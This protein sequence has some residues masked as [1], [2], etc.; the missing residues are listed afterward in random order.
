MKGL[1][2][3]FLERSLFVNLLSIIIVLVGG[4]L[5]YDMNREAFPNIEYDIVIV[6]T[7]WPGSSARDIEKLVTKPIEEKLKEVDGIKEYRSSS[8][9]GRSS[10]TI[11]IDPNVEDDKEIFDDIRN[12]VDRTEGLPS[13][14]EKPTVTEVS[15][16]NLP[17][18]Q[19]A[20]TRS[21]KEDGSFAVSYKQ[22]R[23]M[24]EILENRFLRIHGV[25]RIL[26]RGWRDTEIFVDM[27]P[28]RMRQYLIGSNDVVRVLK[29]RNVSLPGG[30]ILLPKREI[31][32]RTVG[33]F[34][35]VEEILQVPVQ[36]N[37]T[38]ASVKV[39]RIATAYEGFS[40]PDYLE[41]TE[42]S[43]TIS[44]TIIKK[45]SADII[46]VVKESHGVAEEFSST[47]L[48][49]MK[50]VPVNDYSYF[51]RRRLSVLV[52][53]GLIGLVLVVVTLFLFLGWRTALMVALGVP[54][55]F[56]VAFI[57][58][59][60]TGVSL[61]LISMFGLIIVLGIIVDDAIIVSENFYSHLEKGLSPMEAAKKGTGEVIAPV[62]ATIATTIA[63]FA[64]LLFMGG[65]FGKFIYTIPFVVILCLLGSLF[66][67]FAILPSHL[68][69]MNRN[70]FDHTKIKT[71][72]E[73][74]GLSLF[75]KF[76]FHFYEPSL[77]YILKHKGACLGVFIF[78]F[79][80]VVLLQ[81]FFGK[82]K[83]FP[84]AIDILFVKV[85]APV[86]TRKK[87]LLRY[88][89]KMGESVEKLPSS[90]LDSFISRVG[91]Q[92]GDAN[93]P[94]TKRGSHFGMML[95]YLKP[96]IDR[97]YSADTIISFLRKEIGWM[98]RPSKIPLLQKKKD[99]KDE[100]K[101]R[102]EDS[103]VKS[104]E[105]WISEQS[106]QS[107]RKITL[108]RSNRP[109]DMTGFLVNL[110][111]EKIAGGPPVG[112]PI[113]V[114]ISGND[115]ETMV[116]ISSK[117]KKVLNS[118]SGVKDVGDDF[119]PG[120]EEIQV[121]VNES[122]AAQA[123]ISVLDVATAIA[124][125]F[126]GTVATSIRRSTEEVDIRV[127]FPQDYRNST[128]ALSQVYLSNQRGNLIPVNRLASFE[129]GKSISAI[130]HLDGR[131]VISVTANLDERKIS[132]GEAIKKISALT[133]DIPAAYPQYT[134][135]FGGENKDT[136]E[137]LASLQRSFLIGLFAIFMILASLFRSLLQPFVVLSAIPFALIGVILAFFFHGQPFSFMAIM[138]LI[139]LAGV[140]INDSIVL[141]DFANKIK[142]KRPEASNIEVT[143]EAASM[144]LRPVL[145]TTLTT[146]GGLLPT[147]YGIGGFDPFLVPM[148]LAF[149]WGLL[150]S[151]VL[152]LGLVPVLYTFV[153]DFADRKKQRNHLPFLDGVKKI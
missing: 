33:E 121:R 106:K 79:I 140:V 88:L 57:V 23:D 148:A 70:F 139:G 153:L 36:A 72:E 69:D 89:N 137:S 100:D 30:D 136:E 62:L 109:R 64:P 16:S 126:N 147:A 124:T 7:V 58:M 17:V 71:I 4:W 127:R 76:R 108:S 67:C 1:I 120:K 48:P 14:A 146:V 34:D 32:V 141:V 129:R 138:G 38:G 113:A 81:A 56:C 118:I 52:S 130:N 9:E 37:D 6:V 82:F 21:K 12:V 110:Q 87:E 45:G 8:I 125:G 19:W 101:Q 78:A 117:F 39:G 122:L 92:S 49:G 44:L 47:L 91:I 98:Q 86:G 103:S 2:K 18:I 50:L 145:L 66:E 80:F 90:E 54:I 61:N 94:F 55:S 43:D 152:I 11:T 83:L 22:F 95:I 104:L 84:S 5:L 134:I 26:R 96:E 77:Q 28:Q 13:S 25:G 15:S 3:Y 133:K 41:S 99:E 115:F 10:I 29:N 73:K 63:V 51:V 27:D 40:D 93:D 65:I 128:E 123:G 111:V 105:K 107:N 42:N 68:Y 59:A 60:Y 135:Q 142:K 102:R 149:A 143:L 46:E 85:E 112:K 132:S 119:L 151:T 35:K 20:L 131:R 144:R 75:E 114:E 24:A 97:K 74:Q 116:E 53:N 150:F 31:I